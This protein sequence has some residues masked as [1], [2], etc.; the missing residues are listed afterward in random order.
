MEPIQL[1]M[2]GF[3]FEGAKTDSRC[4]EQILTSLIALQ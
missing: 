4:L 2:F 1:C 3:T